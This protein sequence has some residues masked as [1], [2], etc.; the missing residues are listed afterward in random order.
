LL[1]EPMVRFHEMLQ[2]RADQDPLFRFHY[3]TAREM[4]NAALAA[5]DGVASPVDAVR[6]FRYIPLG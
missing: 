6:S 4:A 1:G 3:V 5:A 2:E